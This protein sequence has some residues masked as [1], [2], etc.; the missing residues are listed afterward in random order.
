MLFRS[1]LE[2]TLFGREEIAMGENY[3]E[4]GVCQTERPLA[5]NVFVTELCTIRVACLYRTFVELEGYG[6]YFWVL[7]NLRAAKSGAV[8]QLVEARPTGE[9]K[10]RKSTPPRTPLFRAKFRGFWG[11]PG[12]PRK[13]EKTSN[14]EVF[15]PLGTPQKP[16][17][18]PKKGVPGRPG[19]PYGTP[20][21]HFFP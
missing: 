12:V 3:R 17:K 11:S 1:R 6:A 8:Q 18:T 19:R 13:V 16:P 21:F 9:L 5:F 10:N 14:F 15:D 7:Q 4:K 2:M 20:F